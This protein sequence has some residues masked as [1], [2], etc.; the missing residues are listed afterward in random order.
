MS[1]SRG[2]L[3]AVRRALAI[4]VEAYPRD[5]VSQQTI[6]LYAHELAGCQPEVLLR[7]VRRIIRQDHRFPSLARVLEEYRCQRRLWES[8]RAGLPQTSVPTSQQREES[9]RRAR[10]LLARLGRMG[11]GRE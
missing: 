9:L 5:Q 4:L 7:A 2:D 6:L 8:P 11:S 3:A 1:S 10:E